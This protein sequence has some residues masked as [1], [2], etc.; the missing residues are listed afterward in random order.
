[1]RGRGVT[2]WHCRM[3]ALQL[4]PP[5]PRHLTKVAGDKLIISSPPVILEQERRKGA[6]TGCRDGHSAA[7]PPHPHPHPP[8]GVNPIC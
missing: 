2:V 6:I 7:V 5:P 8:R 1:M 4:S 3:A